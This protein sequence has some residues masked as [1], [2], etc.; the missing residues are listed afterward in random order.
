[1]GTR[2]R[3]GTHME[4][5][6]GAQVLDEYRLIAKNKPKWDRVG[7][8]LG[9]V[10][11]ESLKTDTNAII[12]LARQVDMSKR[13]SARVNFT[14]KDASGLEYECAFLP[15]HPV[16]LSRY[17][18]AWLII[19]RANRLAEEARV[20]RRAKAATKQE[21]KPEPKPKTPWHDDIEKRITQLEQDM[22]FF[23]RVYNRNNQT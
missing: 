6:L 2:I 9:M 22:L 17:I 12:G 21:P 18:T 4:L 11:A 1:M 3:F 7:E 23:T 14:D 19:R 8:T 15:K 13:F 10:V 5:R 20:S 16:S